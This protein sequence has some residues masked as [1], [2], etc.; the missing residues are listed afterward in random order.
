MLFHFLHKH[1]ALKSIPFKINPKNL[2][3]AVLGRVPANAI[4][5]FEKWE[6]SFFQLSV[7]L[8]TPLKSNFK[9]SYG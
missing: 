3:S 8:E 9:V 5:L 1:F 4:F 2:F 6:I 7:K